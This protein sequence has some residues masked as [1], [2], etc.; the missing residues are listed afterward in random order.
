MG[1]V[2]GLLERLAA[3]TLPV[4]VLGES[5]V[6][7]ENAAYAVHH[8][9]R[10]RGPFVA[11]NCAA[12]PENLVESEL[13]GHEKGAFTGAL[14]AKTG[15]FESAA[16]GTVF[17]DEVGE[18]SPAVQAK[19]LRLLEN[20]TVMRVGDTRERA[21]DVRVVAATNR[22]I[23]DEVAAGRFRQDLY[24]RLGGATVLLPP[25]RDR[26]SEIPVLARAFLARAG[27]AAGRPSMDIGPAAMR[28]LLAHDWPGNVRELRNTIEYIVA[29]APDDNVEPTDLPERLGGDPI[30]PDVAPA[31]SALPLTAP[32]PPT[33]FRPIADE[34]REL[35]IR[36][37]REALVAAGGVKTRA[38]ALIDMPIRTFN[39]KLRQYRL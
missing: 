38:A 19:M 14:T 10:R 12:L 8:W 29:T 1:K 22:A 17:L 11:V 15:L 5:G 32:A 24:F 6:G 23:D 21:I 9:S 39:F 28:A 34:V 20:K 16:G 35:E 18:L 30:A 25:L 33:T 4:L 13:F 2:Y 31:A 36:R 27:T 37:M 26:R 3:S 7:K